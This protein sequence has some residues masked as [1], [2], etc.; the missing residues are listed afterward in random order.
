MLEEI[1]GLKV[2]L[3]YG[4]ISAFAITKIGLSYIIAMPSLGLEVNVVLHTSMYI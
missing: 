3:D 4:N 1:Y 2:S